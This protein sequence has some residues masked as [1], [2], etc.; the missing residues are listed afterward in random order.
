MELLVELLVA[1]FV[2]L[3]VPLEVEDCVPEE[4]EL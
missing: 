1:E 2:P 4:V 3:V